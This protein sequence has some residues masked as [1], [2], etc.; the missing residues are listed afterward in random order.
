MT[1]TASKT[2]YIAL[3]LALVTVPAFIDNGA[4]RIA[5]A[6]A[7]N[8]CVAAVV[9]SIARKKIRSIKG[10]QAEAEKR[11]LSEIETSM[12]PIARLLHDKAQLIPVL[13]GQL[14]EVTQHTESAALDIGGRF[15]SIVDRA[16]GQAVKASGAFKTFA[17]AGDDG[18]MLSL[19]KKAL[20][21]VINNLKSVSDTDTQMLKEMQTIMEDA[22]SIKKIVTEIEYIADQTNLLALNAA[23][24]A[25][26]AGEHG[27]GFSI[28]ADEVRKL[29]ERSN[30]AADEIKKLIT[31]VGAD[32]RGIY[33][34]TEKSV[35][36]SN[37][38]SLEAEKVVEQTLKKIDDTVT[39][40]KKQLDELGAETASLAKDISGIVV[41]MQFQD[42]TRQRIEHV[43]EPLTVFK[44]ELEELIQKAKNMNEKIH[45]WEGNGNKKRLEN[46]YTME[47]E[48]K[49][50]RDAFGYGADRDFSGAAE[51]GN[52]MIFK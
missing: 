44:S 31:K 2:G 8:A 35:T 47:S 36:E 19:S 40:L 34:K 49:V 18:A 42:I 15:M 20:T 24:E 6:L 51:T 1:S 10:E 4:V 7:I 13:T 46:M 23:I 16:R 43:I 11:H 33:G 5:S 32:I 17:G 37:S 22:E 50:M 45:S 14:T 41:S 39:D 3:V 52:V 38:M 28:V 48:R 29:S 30:T 12:G 9:L 26:R 25:A 21:G 27:R